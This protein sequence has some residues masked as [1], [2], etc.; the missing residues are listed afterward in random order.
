MYNKHVLATQMD[1]DIQFKKIHG[2][3]AIWYASINL[4][5][6]K[7][8]QINKKTLLYIVATNRPD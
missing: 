1:H 8:L 5:L 2:V 4:V 3:Q 6:Y 7:C